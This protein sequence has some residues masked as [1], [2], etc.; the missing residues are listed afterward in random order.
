MG[1]LARLAE[2]TGL[3]LDV[4]G[5]GCYHKDDVPAWYDAMDES[6]RWQVQARFWRAVAEVCKDTPAIFCYDLMNEPVASGDRK[7]DW[8]PGAPLGGSYFVQRLT[9]DMRGRSDREVAKE[10]IAELSAAIR[11]VDQRH[12]ITVGIV[13]WEET[14]GPGARSAFR[15]PEVSAPLD[16]LCVHYYPRAGKLDDDLA[17]LKLYDIGKPLVIEEIFPLQADVETTAE[18][19]RRSRMEADGW[20][21]FYWGTTPGEY[22][23]E[24]GVKAALNGSWLRHFSAL[25][26]EML[27]SPVSPAHPTTPAPAR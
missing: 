24:P 5:L 14:F 11:A 23:Q 19:I 17:I 20:I 26:A 2:E 6:A 22:D 1:S 3:Y 27:G 12:M 15:D 21:S 18:F 25:R 4:T 13:P 8:L 7:G 9:T 16:F 10:W